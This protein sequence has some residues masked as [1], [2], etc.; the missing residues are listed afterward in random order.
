MS[1]TSG[2]ES[3]AIVGAGFMGAGIAE[4]VA[5]AGLRVLIRDIDDATIERA[6]G[7]IDTS[8]ERA[9]KRGKYPT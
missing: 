7:R 6:R 2:I 4:S 1:T 8:M 5:V 9:V 3:V